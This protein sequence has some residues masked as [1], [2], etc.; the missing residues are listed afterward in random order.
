VQRVG[1]DHDAGEVQ[2]GQQRLEGG[3]FTRRRRPAVGRAPCGWRGPSR[4]AGGPGG[5][6]VGRR[7]A[8]C[9]RPRPPVAAGLAVIGRLRRVVDH[10]IPLVVRLRR[11]VTIA[12]RCVRTFW[13]L[14]HQDA[15]SSDR[16]AARP[17][18]TFRGVEP[19][20]L[21]RM[22]EDP[23]LPWQA[24]PRAVIQA[25]AHRPGASHIGEDCRWRQ[26]PRTLLYDLLKIVLSEIPDQE[27]Y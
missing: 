19:L 18:S 26:S 24:A 17:V 25:I 8:S 4:R 15:D 13:S 23:P 14:Q 11:T 9:R 7:A 3:H 1:G 5:R 20:D 22:A 10:A 12:S 6:R 2:A 16:R 21:G 27:S